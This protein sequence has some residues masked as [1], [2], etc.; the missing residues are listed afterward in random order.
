MNAHE[1]AE[2]T[3]RMLATAPSFARG[4]EYYRQGMVLELYR[5]G[6]SLH[7]VVQGSDVEPYEVTVNIE[8]GTISHAV[9]TCPYEGGGLC[10]HVVAALLA[11]REESEQ[12]EERPIL[13]ELLAPLGRD[14][15]QAILLEL[16]AGNPGIAGRIELLASQ[17]TSA[18]LPGTAAARELPAVEPGV[19]AQQLQAAL[20]PQRG[21]SRRQDYYA[22]VAE[23][24]EVLQTTA[25]RSRPYLDAGDGRSALVFLEAVAEYATVNIEE[26]LGDEGLELNDLCD[27][28]GDLLAEAVLTADLSPPERRQWEK[29]IDTWETRAADYGYEDSFE[30]ARCAAEQGWDDPSLLCVLRGEAHEVD[31]VDEAEWCDAD[32]AKVRLRILERQGRWDE[33]L[34]LADAAGLRNQY[35]AALL[36][37]GRISQAVAYGLERLGSREEALTL[38]RALDAQG[39]AEDAL[40]VAE[41]ALA[42]FPPRPYAF[43]ELPRWTRDLAARLGQPESAL[44]AALMAMRERSTLS[45]YLAVQSL[46]AGHWPELREELL[47]QALA[48]ETSFPTDRL[49]ILLHEG[50]IEEAIAVVDAIPQY[51]LVA[52][53]VAAALVSHPDWVFRA[54]TQQFARIADAGNSQYYREAVQWLEK[55]KTALESTGRRAEWR[56]YLDEQ[57][58]RHKRKYTLRPMLE[59]LR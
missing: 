6:N 10:K 45:D 13:A 37:L 42:R 54:C 26:L 46:A 30:V 15:L 52:R 14:H 55:A 11:F 1:P 49:D 20:R 17:E 7:A 34:R 40:R 25:H 31:D 12:V 57:I 38:S 4:R 24:V 58:A 36:R 27:E 59:R 51:D 53:V 8:E 18:L 16:A 41:Q 39:A 33:Y 43:P 19:V 32:L 48:E 2:D 5:R 21:W 3:I 23:T 44:Q 47:R 56:A 50:L 28:L 29:R 22:G 35:G 9:C